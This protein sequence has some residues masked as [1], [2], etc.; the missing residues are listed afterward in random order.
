M[1]LAIY[2]PI[3]PCTL[4][5]HLPWYPPYTPPW[6]HLSYTPS[7]YLP[8][9]HSPGAPLLPTST[10]QVLTGAVMRCNKGSGL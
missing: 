9:I 10:M 2:Y 8:A 4:H 1:Y 5:I 6:V 7:L 3:L